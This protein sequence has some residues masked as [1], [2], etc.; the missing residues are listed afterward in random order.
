MKTKPTLIAITGVFLLTGIFLFTRCSKSVRAEKTDITQ[1]L[2][3]FN[4]RIKEGNTD[5][6][7][8]YFDTNKQ[9]PVV[10]R[11][12]NLL[13]GKG[14]NGKAKPFFTLSFDV[15]GSDIKIIDAEIIEANLPAIFS[16]DSL[17]HRQSVLTLKIRKAGP[18]QFK[19][20]Q[21]DARQFLTDYMAFENFVKSKTISEKDMFSAITLA[22]FKKAGDLRARYDSVIWFAHLNNKTFFYVVKGKWEIEKDINRFKDSVI[23]PYKMGLVNPEMKEIIPPDFDLIHNISGTFPGLVEVEKNNKK[24]FYDLNGKVIVPV[25]YDQI[26]P[27][28][29]E[30]NLA[31]LRSGKDY[32]YLKKDMSISEKTDLK[33]TDFIAKVKNLTNP[34]D[35]YKNALAVITEYNSKTENGAIYISPSYLVDLNMISKWKDF[36]N[37]LRKRGDNSDD[38]VHKNYKV[39]F[40]G[41]SQDADNWLEVSFYSIRDYFLGGRSEFYDKKN[42]VI[43]DKKNDRLFTQNI[44]TDY[45]EEEG[46]STLQ[47]PCDVNSVK[48]INDSLFEVKSGAGLSIYLYDSTKSV[49]GGPYYHYLAIKNN[50]LVELPD[51]RNFGFT[52]YVKMDDSYL[53]ACYNMIVGRGRSVEG[54]EKTIDHVTE[55]MLRYMKNEIYADYRYQ[56]KDKRWE[57]VFMYSRL[58]NYSDKA[59]NAS[60]DDSL[61]VVDKYNINFLNQKLRASKTNTLAA[62]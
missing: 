30:V 2:N 36:E 4:N 38:E 40:S 13:A 52:K 8:T 3:G 25:D 49:T 24:G 14:F 41:K 32:Y 47:S 58:S 28:T 50:K 45:S 12:V 39:A 42:L 56:F 7:L 21:T 27:I 55:D 19:I 23:E 10:K 60:V 20:I 62:K 57:E 1:F 6:L 34:V 11:L 35:L 53:V 16:H 5:S 48:I 22:A 44:E 54:Q 18:H 37:P 46:A 15:D 17:G 26:F 61:T 59:K 43:I 31:V 33:I 51:N 9:L 29:D